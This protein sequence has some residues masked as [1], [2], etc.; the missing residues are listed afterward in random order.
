MK[1]NDFVEDN[2]VNSADPVLPKT[3]PDTGAVCGLDAA[4]TTVVF[5]ASPYKFKE[6]IAD[7]RLGKLVLGTAIVPEY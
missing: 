3:Y 5:P 6:S 7:L 1:V 4:S 2:V